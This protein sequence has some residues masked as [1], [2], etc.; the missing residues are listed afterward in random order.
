M[1]TA[2][3]PLA[4]QT[5]NGLQ[6]KFETIYE[7][8]G[9]YIF[10]FLYRMTGNYQDAEDLAQ[11]TFI[12]AYLALSRYKEEDKVKP[13]LFRIATNTGL[14][15]LRRRQIIKAQPW[16]NFMSVFHPQQIAKEDTERDVLRIEQTELVQKILDNLSPRYRLGLL[17][18]EY[19]DF[20]CREIAQILGTTEKAVKSLLW[21]ARE[22][23]RK[24]SQWID[25]PENKGKPYPR[26]NYSKTQ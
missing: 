21:R 12:K 20:S 15:E 26:S 8:Y 1:V 25:L 5:D 9:L 19:E 7:E 23:F 4:I 10:N 14:D 13:W 18:K 2:E 22:E 11:T 6:T 24:I 17:L 3:K 16:D